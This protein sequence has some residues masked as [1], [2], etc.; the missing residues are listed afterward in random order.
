MH[1]GRAL[2]LSGGGVRNVKR[3]PTLTLDMEI[4]QS[5]RTPIGFRGPR[6]ITLQRSLLGNGLKIVIRGEDKEDRAAA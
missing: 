3:L 6:R 5:L 4:N 2:S 1:P